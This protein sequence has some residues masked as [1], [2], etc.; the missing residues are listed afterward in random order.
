MYNGKQR[1][2]RRKLKNL[3]SNI[4]KFE[5]FTDVDIEYEHFHVP[6][7]PWIECPKTSGKVKTIFIKKWLEKT[8]EFIENKPNE[9]QFY[10]VVA[11]IDSKSLY[12]SQII[13]FY[14]ESYY[15]NF[16]KRKNYYQ[17]WE[18]LD[19]KKSLKQRLNIQT[20]LKEIGFKE[21]INDDD[22]KYETELWF[23]GEL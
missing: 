8:V 22:Y 23:Y 19:S 11:V 2:Q 10:K 18:K 3:L 6:S 13:I 9:L 1:G 17:T 15:N 20:N 5:A 14:S 12:S 16:W 7:T 4:D 21:T